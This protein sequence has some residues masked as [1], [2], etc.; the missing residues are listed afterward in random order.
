M[1]S[2]TFKIR[3]EVGPGSS[4]QLSAT[5]TAPTG[6][7]TYTGYWRMADDKG[8]LFGS[9]FTVSIK[10]AGATF[11]PTTPVSPSETPTLVTPTN[12]PILSDTPAPSDTPVPSPTS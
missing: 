12:T 3:Q 1:G 10:V 5:F 8:V 9:L 6:P 2:D 7:G 11:T 4:A